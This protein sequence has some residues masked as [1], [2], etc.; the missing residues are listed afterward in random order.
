MNHPK[1]ELSLPSARNPR[2]RKARDNLTP[3]HNRTYLPGDD[4]HAR[5]MQGIS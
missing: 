2:Q 5:G 3:E 1:A 4:K